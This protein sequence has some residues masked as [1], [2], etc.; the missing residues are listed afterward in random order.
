M[1]A[2]FRLA[3]VV[4]LL[5]ALFA[6]REAPAQGAPR[7]K[8]VE[9]TSGKVGDTVTVLGENLDKRVVVAVYLSDSSSDHKATVVEQS[10][11][12]IVVKVPRVKSG[13]YNI[14]IQIKNDILIQPV[15]FTVQE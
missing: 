12:K 1:S 8:G 4:F 5:A 11:E 2:N 3:A 10:A 15:R 6:A 14:S 9:P 7:V 13:E